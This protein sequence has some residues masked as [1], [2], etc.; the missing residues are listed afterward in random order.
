MRASSSLFARLFIGV[1][2]IAGLAGCAL[3]PV[4]DGGPRPQSHALPP[5]GTGFGRAVA[6]AAAAHPGRSGFAVIE[7]GPTAFAAREALARGAERTLDVQYFIWEPDASGLAL[8]VR[9]AEAAERGVR[10]RLLLDD[11][12]QG[13]N[14]AALALLDAH[15]DAEV[16]LYNPAPDRVHRKAGFVTSFDTFNHRMHNKAFIADTALGIIGGR[17]ISDKYFVADKRSNFRDLDLLAAGPVVGAIA[18]SFGAYWAHPLS[19]RLDRLRA[20][21]RVA[22]PAGIPGLLRLRLAGVAQAEE[23]LRRIRRAGPASGRDRPL[24]R[25]GA[26]VWAPAVV[27]ADGAAK[28]LTGRPALMRALRA[29]LGGRPRHDLLFEMAYVVP[30][31]ETRAWLCGMAADGVTVRGLTNSF[32]SND[33]MV[34]HSGYAEVREELARCGLRLSELR[35]DA[36]FVRHKWTWLPPRSNAL[37]HTK[38]MVFDGRWTFISSLNLDP[39]SI[40]L[41]TELGV[42]VDSPRLSARVTRFIEEGMRLDNAYRVVLDGKGDLSWITR[43]DGRVVRLRTEPRTDAWDRAVLRFLEWLPL[44]GML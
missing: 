36:G 26:M 40:A 30:G 43:Y 22:D 15:P 20:P 5:T 27:L 2:L 17:N 29:I 41:N 19:V 14:D 37:L 7:G 28:P 3:G 24:P 44:E 8:L 18:R 4:Q 1:L 42:L 16:R 31:P 21:A 6:E 34:T 11:L 23:K 12:Y 32:A 25:P 13:P 9:L 39:R 38:A 35:A 33:L 10:V